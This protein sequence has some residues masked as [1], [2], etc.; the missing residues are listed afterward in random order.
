MKMTSCFFSLASGINRLVFICLLPWMLLSPLRLSA[1]TVDV[2]DQTGKTIV[3][4]KES[5]ALVIW[6]GDYRNPFWK[7]L[8]NIREEADQVSAALM[9]QGF[10]V[11]VVANPTA[12]ELSGSIEGFVERHGYAPDNR[13]VVYYAGHGWTRKNDFG[14][15]VP[16]DA[17]DASTVQ[18]DLDF[19]KMALSMEQIVSWS[20]QMEAKHVLFVFDS[21]F[22]GTVFKVRGA[23]IPPPYIDKKINLPVREFITAGD[24][25]EEVPAKSI[26]TPLLVRGLDGDADLNHDG[27]ITG[28]EL[29]D[30]LPQ[31]MS[32]YTSSQN[33]QYGKIQD[34]DLDQGDIVFLG[35]GSDSPPRASITTPESMPIAPSTTPSPLA[36]DALLPTSQSSVS[37]S[38]ISPASPLLTVSAES[39]VGPSAAVTDARARL[40]KGASEQRNTCRVVNVAGTDHYKCIVWYR[41]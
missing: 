16:I 15:L 28:S 19:A 34:P 1:A 21:C 20:K 39:I 8:N 17:P 7:K 40:P 33:P 24:A 41:L 14:Y 3:G 30:Y 5:H 37:V 23:S 12:A 4:Y 26:F 11:T 13:L 25:N 35:S 18:G 10:Q 32:V 29:G 2:R 36:K 31:A 27:Y 9:R 6:A 38:P 22:S